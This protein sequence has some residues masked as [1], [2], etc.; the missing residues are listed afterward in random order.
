MVAGTMVW[1]AICASFVL[2]FD[3]MQEIFN[4]VLIQP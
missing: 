2:T 3:R 1:E 4:S